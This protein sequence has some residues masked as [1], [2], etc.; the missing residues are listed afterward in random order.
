MAKN[1]EDIFDSIMFRDTPGAPMSYDEDDAFSVLL[2]P[3][4]KT[5]PTRQ[6]SKSPLIKRINSQ[7]SH[8]TKK[9]TLPQIDESGFITSRSDSSALSA[10]PP[11]V[12]VSLVIHEE[13]T[14]QQEKKNDLD[15]I[16]SH[17]KIEGTAHAQLVSSNAGE[18]PPFQLKVFDPDY[19]ADDKFV[20]NKNFIIEEEQALDGSGIK[21]LVVPKKVIGQIQLA[22]WE[23]T[24]V[25]RFMPV[26]L[27]S[28][29]I[30]TAKNS[31]RCMVAIQLRSNLNNKGSLK[32]LTAT[33]AVPP[34]VIGTS[35]EIKQGEGTFDDLKRIIT[36][37]LKELP[38]GKSL[39]F[40]FEVDILAA[41]P[42]ED[43]PK[44]PI[45]I[46]CRSTDDT[47]SSV[48]VNL[49]KMQGHPA[50]LVVNTYA[51]FRLLHR[52]PS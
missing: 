22:S 31:N 3:E 1:S 39:M 7:R 14:S 41:L 20:L 51:S 42:P 17:V 33:V 28:K 18:N 8:S 35:L 23:R 15:D 16:V 47:I 29:V 10:L 48:E 4:N 24:V 26:L 25:K 43:V 37:T 45:L 32:A 5:T 12:V 19:P 40:G 2:S 49:E 36:W 21:R 27:Q 46:R 34:T 9:G 52:L 38:V 11:K 44:F 6:K 13:A 50:T 30:R